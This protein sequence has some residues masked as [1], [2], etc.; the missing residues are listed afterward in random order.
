MKRLALVLSLLVPLNAYAAS[1]ISNTNAFGWGANLGWTNWH[2]ADI[3]AP[4]GADGVVIGEFIC[5]GYIYSANVGWINLGNAFVPTATPTL[6]IHY[7]NLT[8]TDFGVNYSIDPTQP[9][10]A[11]LRG[12]AYGANVGWINFEA[13][14]N[15]RLSLFTGTFSGYAY[16][17]NCGWINLNDSLGKVQTDH[18]A[19]GVDSDSDGIADAFEFQYFGNLTSAGA[20]T[21]SDGD[22]VSDKGEYLDG[23]SPTIAS[24]RLR[25]VTFATNSAGASSPITW[26]STVARL[27]IIETKPDLLALSWDPDPIF[28]MAFAP[29]AST[30]TT[31]TITAASATKR[32]YRVRSIRPL[33]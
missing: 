3:G 9:G 23:T 25:I 17:A 32:F 24:D 1:T 4:A 10:V 19:M 12:Y 26:T 2:D 29:D 18:V 27:Y 13:L 14:G 30:S 6:H 22:G 33:P 5:S 31:R 28:G 16:S 21:D 15:P 8:A 7:S 20:T 11:I